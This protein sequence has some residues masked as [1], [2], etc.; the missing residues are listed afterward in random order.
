MSDVGFIRRS[1]WELK[2]K[3]VVGVSRSASSS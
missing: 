2:E 3:R 1:N